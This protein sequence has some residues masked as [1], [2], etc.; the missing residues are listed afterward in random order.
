MCANIALSV[1]RCSTL[2]PWRF[3]SETFITALELEW[4][5]PY[6]P[7]NS[8]QVIWM[9]TSEKFMT[10]CANL[11]PIVSS[12]F[13]Q[14]VW[15]ATSEMHTKAKLRHVIRDVRYFLPTYSP[16][17]EINS[18]VTLT[19]HCLCSSSG[20]PLPKDLNPLCQTMSVYFDFCYDGLKGAVEA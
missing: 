5:A 10:M 11:A 4:S 9:L 1:L 8:L 20:T 14:D 3:T 18:Y 6:A 2:G 13:A 17:P 19:F 16:R 12:S 15:S 7:N